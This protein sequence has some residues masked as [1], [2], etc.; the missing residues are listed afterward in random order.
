MTINY[1]VQKGH[2]LN[3]L[4]IA[5]CICL[6]ISLVHLFFELI[7]ADKFSWSIYPRDL[8][9]WY[10]VFTGHFIHASWNHLLSNITPLFVSLTMIFF[11]YRSIGWAV[12]F[13]IWIITGFA[14]FM[15]ARSNSH[16]GASGLVYGLI[17]FVFFSG[18]F[19]RNA[20]SIVLMIIM[21]V[22]YGSYTAGFL[23]LDEKVSFE[24]H[25]FGALAGLW[26]A[27]VFRDFREHDEEVQ[28][29]SW[30][31]ENSPKEYFFSKDLFDKTLQ[32]RKEEEE[33]RQREEDLNL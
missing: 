21:T 13:M 9:Q 25:I 23:P 8:S 11:F 33:L 1:K 15:F 5:F 20:K 24:S 4:L 19:R 28:K 32:Q 7:P 12:Y 22:M 29:P 18:V 31:G 30:S 26:T 3:S 10:G 27:F 17:A 14:V 6:F 2:F 16:L